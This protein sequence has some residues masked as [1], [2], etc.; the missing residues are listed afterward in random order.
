MS[1][2]DWIVLSGT[3]ALI[4]GY[5]T[6]KSRAV[7]DVETYLRGGRDIRWYAV[8]LSIM[9][10]QASAITFL[11]VPGQAYEDGLG[12]VQ[13]Y[14]GLPIAMVLLAAI[15]TPIYFRLKVYTAYEYLER[16]FDRKTRQ[17][18]ALL[19]LI[20]RG[21][22]AGLSIYAPS[23]ILSTVFGWPLQATNLAIGLLVILYTVSGGTRAVNQTQTYQMIVILGGMAAAFGFLLH[24]LPPQ[25]SFG[26]ALGIA[27]VLGKMKA[28][29]LSPHLGTRYTLWTGLTGGL[30][31]Q[32]AYFGTDQSQVQR[33]LSGSTLSESRLGLLMNGL[34]K[35][36]M[37]LGVL[38]VGVLVF[39][40]YQFHQPPVFFNQA[41]LE[42]VRATPAAPEL[43]ALESAFA[44]AWGDKKRDLEALVAARHDGDSVELV[45]AR[46][47]L[48]AAEAR[49]Q[50]IRRDTKDV[51][52]RAA[53]RA[54]LKDAD[55][56]FIRFVTDQFPAGL[57]GLLVAVIFCAA[58]SASAAALNALSTTTV[59]DLYKRSIKPQASDRHYLRA[60]QLFTVFWGLLAVSFAASAALLDNL[61]QAVNILGSIFYGPMLGVFLVGFF[62][63][64]V[65]GTP[66][67][68]ATLIA[69]TIVIGTFLYSSI[70]FLWYNVIGCAALVGLALALE[71]IARLLARA[72]EP[73][74]R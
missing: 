59:I 25:V 26:D 51:I 22:A 56:I 3:V 21:L 39:V 54:E 15:V 5:G 36:P 7:R 32:L 60:A 73:H 17:L 8:G 72:P 12:F 52:G 69:Q 50:A 43:R 10:T 9:A 11:S 74:P 68:V 57:L 4:V 63:K 6:W 49:T 64:W 58:M 37:Q 30:F 66:V 35:I 1:S 44:G 27:G 62:I 38:L 19:F 61:I 71:A 70:G 29:D 14:F 41:E 13:F 45:R 2:L 18:T 53:P 23:I 31:V 34:V 65:R 40:F 46:E 47:R 24:R 16:R 28:V 20:A 67:F 33:Y 42:R 55:Y 48:R